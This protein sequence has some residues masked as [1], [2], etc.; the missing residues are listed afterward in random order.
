VVVGSAILTTVNT[1]FEDEFFYG[2]AALR[3]AA[4]QLSILSVPTLT[5]ANATVA[6]KTRGRSAS[7]FTVYAPSEN[8]A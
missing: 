1:P 2:E 4:V 7:K 6:G 3:K 5:G 8:A